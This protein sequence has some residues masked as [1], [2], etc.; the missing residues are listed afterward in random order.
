MRNQIMKNKCVANKS[1][2]RVGAPSLPD[3]CVIVVPGDDI[4]V[5]AIFKSWIYDEPKRKSR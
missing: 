1:A 5:S 4:E 3:R 2:R